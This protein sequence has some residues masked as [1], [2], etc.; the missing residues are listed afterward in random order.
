MVAFNDLNLNNRKLLEL[1]GMS[2]LKPD[3]EM[4]NIESSKLFFNF[5]NS[6][7][8]KCHYFDILFI[9]LPHSFNNKNKLSLLHVNISSLNKHENFDVLYE[10]LIS[11]P[12]LSNVTCTSTM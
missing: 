7:I 2:Q 9:N 10:F 5:L 3:H 11:I 4:E 8:N 12:F 1:L 6:N